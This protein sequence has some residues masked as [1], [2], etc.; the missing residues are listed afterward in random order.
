MRS[1]STPAVLK[2]AAAW[3]TSTSMLRRCMLSAMLAQMMLALV[4]TQP[5]RNNITAVILLNNSKSGQPI[6]R[7]GKEADNQQGL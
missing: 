1:G 7:G 6:L 3:A 5:I 4:S 2:A